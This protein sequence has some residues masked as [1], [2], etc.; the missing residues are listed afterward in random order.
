MVTNYYSK[1][2]FRFLFSIS[3]QGLVDSSLSVQL[4][5]IFKHLPVDTFAHKIQNCP[6]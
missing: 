4:K 5:N 3:N 6:G 2:T 1:R